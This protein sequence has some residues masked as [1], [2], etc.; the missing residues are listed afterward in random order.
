[1]YGNDR[2]VHSDVTIY[3]YKQTTEHNREGQFTIMWNDPE[4]DIKCPVKNPILSKRDG[5]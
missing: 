4:Y 3:H 5:G 1:M 2:L